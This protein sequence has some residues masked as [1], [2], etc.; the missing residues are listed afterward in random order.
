MANLTRQQAKFA[1]VYCASGFDRKRACAE[2]G[3][4][5]RNY[6]TIA[7]KLLQ[8]AHVKAKIDEIL[9]QA[10]QS[11]TIQAGEVIQKL[12][13]IAFAPPSSKTSN[14]DRI[15][16]LKLLGSSLGLYSDRL[17]VSAET[18]QFD[19]TPQ[20]REEL[21]RFATLHMK[22]VACREVP[23]TAEITIHAP[24]YAPS[25]GLTR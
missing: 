5:V 25:K 16:A 15:Q 17:S 22:A 13:E 21:Q 8:K 19:L 24:A 3:Y 4:S 9:N 10:T 1:E 11:C 18:P 2:A 7:C 14:S 6:M 23:K 12:R 20:E